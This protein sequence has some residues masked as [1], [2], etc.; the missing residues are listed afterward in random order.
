MGT[1]E[2]TG[3]NSRCGWRVGGP[4]TGRRTPQTAVLI[5]AVLDS[6]RHPQQAYRCCL[7]LLRLAKCHSDARLKAVAARALASGSYSYR[8]VE[9]ILKHRFDET[10]AEPLE[11]DARVEYDNVRGVLYYR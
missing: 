8:S 3:P 10:A 6:R 5:T 11:R 9:S 4:A 1:T 2:T 7:G